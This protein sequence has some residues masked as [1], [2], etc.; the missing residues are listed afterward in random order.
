MQRMYEHVPPRWP[1]CHVQRHFRVH[2]S[3][4][5]SC[6]V[7]RR[8]RRRRQLA[9]ARQEVWVYEREVAVLPGFAPSVG[10]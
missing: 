4:L 8:E 3:A 7:Q 2:L 9:S 1:Q 5:V 10:D 6:A